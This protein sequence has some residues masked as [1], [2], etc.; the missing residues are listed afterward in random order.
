MKPVIVSDAGPLIALAKL[1]L[2]NLLPQIFSTVY[3][4]KIV[5][6]EATKNQQREDAQRIT[7]YFSPKIQ[8]INNLENTFSKSLETLLDDGEIQAL[9]HAKAL[10][11]SVLMD[12]KRGRQIAIHNEIPVVGIIGVLLQARQQDLISEVKH[13]LLKLQDVDYRL[14]DSLLNRALKLAGEG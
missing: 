13:Y 1:D 11:C 9:T 6:E 5:F 2:L 3:I 4:P 7:N 10:K 14:S 12:E 8:I